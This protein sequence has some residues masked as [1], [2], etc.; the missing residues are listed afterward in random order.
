MFGIGLPELIIIMV[1]A[2]V[3]I[4]PNKLPDLA[5][6]LGKGMAEF[7]K[8]TQ[9]IKDSL[10]LDE[11]IRD[12][13]NEFVDS[14]S[15]LDKPPDIN[16]TT[17]KGTEEVVEPSESDVSDTSIDPNKENAEEVIEPSERVDTDTSIDDPP[18]KE[19][20]KDE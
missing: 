14:I 2:L 10:E 15:G 20:T 8:A 17:D 9:D 18:M 3:V 4:G 7:R 19:N 16:E 5:R 6:A 1:I 12:I 11:G 13:K